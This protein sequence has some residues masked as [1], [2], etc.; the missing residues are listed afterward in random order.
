MALGLE[1]ILMGL[2]RE[3]AYQPEAAFLVGEYPHDNRPALDLLVEALK[4]VGALHVFMMLPREPVEGERVLDDF[5][6]PTRQLLIARRPFL[7]PRSE[8]S[9][10]LR[11][12]AT[13]IDPA[14]FLQAV[15]V[16]LARQ[17]IER[18]AQKMHVTALEP[19]FRQDL[20][21]SRPQASVIVGNDIFDTMET[22][23]LQ[24]DEEVLPGRAAFAI[25]MFDCQD[26][27]AAL[28]INPE[29]DQHP[30]RTNNA[31]LAD[32]LVLRIDD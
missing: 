26:L 10:G 28:P 31:C 23:L 7:Q 13:V 20:A 30:A 1:P 16:G 4:H 14:Q 21:D 8:I 25:G 3:C 18:V 9:F 5:L 22:A 15:V 24:A 17:M 27:A 11:D 2:D 6:D 12:L 19:G 29:R 32:L